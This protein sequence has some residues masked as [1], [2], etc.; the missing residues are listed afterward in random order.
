VQAFVDVSKTLMSRYGDRIKYWEIWN[1]P[2]AWT[3]GNYRNDPA[4]AGGTY[5]LPLVYSKLLAETYVQNKATITSHGL[6]L[7]AGGLFAH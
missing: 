2:N 1:E 3:N 6:H 5:M 7:I 4:H